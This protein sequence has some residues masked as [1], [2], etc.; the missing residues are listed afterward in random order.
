MFNWFYDLSSKVKLFIL[1]FSL[2]AMIIL[3]AGMGYYSSLKSIDSAQNIAT[4]INRSAVR[5]NNVLKA[6]RDFDNRNVVFLSDPTAYTTIDQFK[7]ETAATMG[8]IATTVN[9]MNPERVGDLQSSPAYRD[10]IL[11]IKARMA[12]LEGLYNNDFLPKLVQDREDGVAYY[13]QVIRPLISDSYADCAFLLDSQH[14]LVIELGSK[15]SERTLSYLGC[16]IAVFAV[17]LG[18]L[19]AWA[20]CS[21]INTCVQRQWDLIKEMS[22]GNFRFAV[23]QYHKDDFGSIIADM[24]DLRD[25]INHELSLVKINSD[26]TEQS[27]SQVMDLSNGIVQKVADCDSRIVSV[28]AASE[29]MLSTTQEIAKNCEQVTTM[30]ADTKAT[31][32][33]GVEK[34]QQT[35]EAIRRQSEEIQDNSKA[36]EKVAKRSLDI[37]SIVNTIEGI[38]AQTNLLALNAAIEAARAGEAGRGFAVV[39]DEVRALASRTA[40]STQEIADMVSDI[41]KDA[42]AATSSISNS[43]IAMEETSHN[44]VEVETTMHEMLEHVNSVDAQITQIASATEEQSVA[45]HEISN[46][47][48]D[49]TILAQETNERSAHAGE[50]VNDTVDNIHQL[51]KSLSFF[52]LTE[53]VR[54]IASLDQQ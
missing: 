10:H 13:L 19:L 54:H 48:H 47:I 36:V 34:I 11:T 50:I 27:L 31:I 21:Y 52:K 42:A 12:K 2:I 4:I 23:P 40:S 25:N 51:K 1:S 35:I 15:G 33:E 39:A 24:C 38:A 29:E 14:K 32:G 6:I 16:A 46:N 41:Q 37:N 43:V 45:T 22:Q 53:D 49:V 3:V 26:K 9:I 28:S 7:S 5:V 18:I 20:I 30:S 8:D 17:F 44:T